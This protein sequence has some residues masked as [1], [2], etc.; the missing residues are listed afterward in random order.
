[1]SKDPAVLKQLKNF[2][3]ENNNKMMERLSPQKNQSI[4]RKDS[5][6]ILGK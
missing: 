5:L 4:L 6:K 1:M 2:K 3:P